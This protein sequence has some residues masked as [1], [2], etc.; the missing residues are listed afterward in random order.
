MVMGC[1]CYGPRHSFVLF[2]LLV[3][4]TIKAF[5]D[6]IELY[7]LIYSVWKSQRNRGKSAVFYT[8]PQSFLIT[9]SYWLNN[10]RDFSK[11]LIGWFIKLNVQ[12]FQSQNL[13]YRMGNF[14]YS[15]WECTSIYRPLSYPFILY[16]NQQEI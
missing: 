9:F 1:L 16:E 11:I 13:I 14:V 10:F 4:H 2:A 15:H 7:L 5:A 3:R 8:S 12:T 6:W